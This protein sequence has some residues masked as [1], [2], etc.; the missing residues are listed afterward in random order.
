[1]VEF[2]DTLE[3]AR[4]SDAA[5][6]SVLLILFMLFALLCTFFMGGL[7]SVIEMPILVTFAI[8][9]VL[10]VIFLVK[11]IADRPVS[12]TQVHWIFYVTFL[13]MAPLSQ[14]LHDYSCWGYVLSEG[15]F[16]TTNLL[17]FVWGALFALFS[18]LGIRKTKSSNQLSLHEDF[19][20]RLPVVSA[21]AAWCMALIALVATTV[22]VATV[23]FDNLFSR[24]EYTTGFSR[25]G[26]LLFDKLIRCCPAFALA[27]AL[28]RFK[29][30]RDCIAPLFICAA[31]TIVSVFPAGVPRYTAATIY[32]GLMLLACPPLLNRKGVFPLLFLL[33]FLL[34][35]PAINVF[36]NDDFSAEMF[37]RALGNV[38]VLLPEGFCAEDYDAY[39]ML[40][41]SIDYIETYGVTM[42]KQ[43][44]TVLFFFVPRSLWAAKAQGSGATIAEAQGQFYTNLAC[45]AP[46]EGI[47]N[48]GII[49]L[50]VFAVVF[51]C[52]CRKADIAFAE[53][54][55]IFLLFYPFACPMLFFILRGDLLSSW[56]YL[57]GFAATFSILAF[58]ALW[59]SRKIPPS[60]SLPRMRGGSLDID[61][62]RKR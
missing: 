43:L 57:V 22:L 38:L 40:A 30:S 18:S 16:L 28:V 37:F 20:K 4:L 23:G 54:S 47:M 56:A 62:D 7:R 33:A 32:G 29:Q 1:M 21:R 45:P 48:Y 8:N 39:S 59:L 19:Y 12:L 6:L 10:G 60:K 58:S 27:L 51:A 49:G 31:A 17:L 26:D 13:V 42:G 3:G 35:F 9:G 53:L 36:R 2:R 5:W 24:A 11:S 25:M 15:D 55:S 50:V 46:A 41:R 14:Y 34:V 52:A 61:V 44:I